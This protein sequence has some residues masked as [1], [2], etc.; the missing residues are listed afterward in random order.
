MPD[1]WYD[2]TM[3]GGNFNWEGPD[4][5]PYAG[6]SIVGATASE[7]DITIFD[8][9]LDDGDLSSGK[10]RLTSNGRH[11]YIIDE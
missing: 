10:F 4:Y 3:L 1:D 5:Y 11:T 2:P 9:I 6:I 8:K 7:H